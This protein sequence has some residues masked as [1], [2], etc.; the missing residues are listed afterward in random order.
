[1]ESPK[2]QLAQRP[3]S[4]HLSTIADHPAQKLQI[5]GFDDQICEKFYLFNFHR[6]GGVKVSIVAFQAIDP[7]SIPGWRI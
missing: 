6:V 2:D 7:G 4:V 5:K 3:L 1:M